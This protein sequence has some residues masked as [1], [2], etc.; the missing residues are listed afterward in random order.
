MKPPASIVERLKAHWHR[1]AHLRL[2]PGATEAALT[3]FES[4]YR[5][6]LPAVVRE[7]FRMADGFGAPADQDD[8]GFRF[9]PLAEVEPLSSYEGG[10]FGDHGK[11]FIFA[12]YLL[13]SWAYG[14]ALE[15]RLAPVYMIGT[16]DGRPRPVASSF[17]EF[18]ARY[19]SD[20]ESLYGSLPSATEP[21]P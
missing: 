18:V 14:V 9:W 15:A 7:Y 13:W 16:A 5:T 3:A 19:I 2:R 4:R 1:Q 8:E 12:D 21:G 6:A 10:R 17:E 20:H 11:I